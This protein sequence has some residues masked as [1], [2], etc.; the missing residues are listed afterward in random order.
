MDVGHIFL[1]N[2]VRNRL[3]LAIFDICGRWLYDYL[4]DFITKPSSHR[5]YTQKPWFHRVYV[6]MFL[7][8]L[9]G[10]DVIFQIQI[11]VEHQN[12]LWDLVISTVD[13]FLSSFKIQISLMRLKQIYMGLNRVLRIEKL[14]SHILGLHPSYSISGQQ[15]RNNYHNMRIYIYMH[16]SIYIY[17]KYMRISLKNDG[18]LT[19]SEFTKPPFLSFGIIKTRNTNSECQS[20]QL[21]TRLTGAPNDIETLGT[22]GPI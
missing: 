7:D 2:M 15:P 5:E 8:I 20:P 13:E 4:A 1:K 18:S 6:D 11:E 16:L 3:R 10:K 22:N 17:Y 9:Y 14:L 19:F 21:A 12:I